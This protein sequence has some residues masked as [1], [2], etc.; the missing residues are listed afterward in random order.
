[1]LVASLFLSSRLEQISKS[2]L[3]SLQTMEENGGSS[4]HVGALSL[5]AQ[6]GRSWSGQRAVAAARLCR[7]TPGSTHGPRKAAVVQQ[8][9]S[10]MCHR[11]S[12]VQV[13][14][15]LVG[16]SGR[17]GTHATTPTTSEDPRKPSTLTRYPGVALGRSVRQDRSQRLSSLA[18]TSRL[19]G[20]PRRHRLRHR[21]RRRHQHRRRHRHLGHAQMIIRTANIGPAWVSASQ[22]PASC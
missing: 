2:T 3:P 18:S 16:G 15:V 22:T 10:T 11:L 4:Y 17:L 9:Q 12:R 21:H 1:M 13:V 7:A 14:R 5:L 6:A 19:T 20:R 8:A